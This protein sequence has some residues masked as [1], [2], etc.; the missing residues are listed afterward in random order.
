M[1]TVIQSFDTGSMKAPSLT[2]LM[3]I[4]ADSEFPELVP[5]YLAPKPKAIVE[6]IDLDISSGD[7]FQKRITN[8]ATGKYDIRFSNDHGSIYARVNSKGDFVVLVNGYTALR[9]KQEERHNYKPPMTD[10]SE[11]IKALARMLDAFEQ[12]PVQHGLRCG[13]GRHITQDI[14]CGDLAPAVN[15]IRRRIA[16]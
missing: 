4:A 1:D 13:C 7:S 11:D 3:K 2:D 12:S 6:T 10:L 5:A 15:R 8:K 9:I 14:R 16:A